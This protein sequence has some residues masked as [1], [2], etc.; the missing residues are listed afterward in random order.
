MRGGCTCQPVGRRWG[1]G[2]VPR[3]GGPVPH[4][5]GPRG[6]GGGHGVALRAK[7]LGRHGPGRHACTGTCCC[8]TGFT[9]L[10]FHSNVESLLLHVWAVHLCDGRCNTGSGS[11]HAAGPLACNACR[12]C[13][14]VFKMHDCHLSGRPVGKPCHVNVDRLPVPRSLPRHRPPPPSH[15]TVMPCRRQRVWLQARAAPPPTPP[16]GVPQATG[17]RTCGPHFLLPC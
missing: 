14:F 3:A 15:V 17:P 5:H 8:F 16:F 6:V 12:F 10:R 13:S 11:R 4:L 1:A 7:W 2:P 9:G